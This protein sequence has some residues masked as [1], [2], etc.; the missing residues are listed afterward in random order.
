MIFA[1]IARSEFIAPPTLGAFFECAYYIAGFV[2]AVAVAIAAVIHIRAKREKVPQPLITKEHDEFV[3]RR[4]HKEEMTRVDARFTAL[5]GEA[6]TGR[7]EAATGRSNL[8][9]HMEAVKTEMNG[10]IESVRKDMAD[11]PAETINLLLKTKE[12]NR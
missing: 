12:L 9:V 7:Q 10:K 4:E 5:Q 3:T 1:E 11:I 8:H 2:G 6:A